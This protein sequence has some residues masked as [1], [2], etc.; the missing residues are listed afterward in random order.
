MDTL[1]ILAISL[2]G[3]GLGALLA[4]RFSAKSHRAESLQFHQDSFNALD[5]IIVNARRVHELAAFIDR[6]IIMH[7]EMTNEELAKA[8]IDNTKDIS[9]EE[10]SLVTASVVDRA[11]TLMG[12]ALSD[13][14]MSDL[15]Q[16]VIR[17]NSLGLI[18]SFRQPMSV[19]IFMLSES[20]LSLLKS[21]P[22]RCFSLLTLNRLSTALGWPDRDNF[23]LLHEQE[24][25]FRAMD[26]V[27]EAQTTRATSEF[28]DRALAQK[29]A[30]S[31][32]AAL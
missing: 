25:L 21:Q 12:C 29:S 2:V 6:L 24:Q 26:P 30:S 5:A 11:R 1:G 9:A 7:P 32:N 15:A 17:G 4:I 13:R 20:L 19:G 31:Q 3:S 22:I 8:V 28:I 27:D 16:H 14:Q 23:L 18:S 10:R